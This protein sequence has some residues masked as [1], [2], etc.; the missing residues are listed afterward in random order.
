MESVI[1]GPIYV[2]KRVHWVYNRGFGDY[3]Q[4][5][6]RKQSARSFLKIVL[7]TS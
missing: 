1:G 5:H 4:I 3:L 6:T 2:P 7:R